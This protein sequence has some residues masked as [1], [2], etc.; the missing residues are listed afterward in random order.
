MKMSATM[1]VVPVCPTMTMT[2]HQ[3]DL[4]Q[5]AYD[6]MI[7]TDQEPETGLAIAAEIA[8]VI[9]KSDPETV[10]DHPT[11]HPVAEEIETNACGGTTIG[12]VDR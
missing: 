2:V 9:P 6:M 10:L 8:T 7:T 5:L 1:R 11:V 3:P 4:Q 12:L